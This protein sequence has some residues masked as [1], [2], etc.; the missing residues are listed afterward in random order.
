MVLYEAIL[1]K[2]SKCCVSLYQSA[3]FTKNLIELLDTYKSKKLYIASGSDQKEFVE[4]FESR[5]LMKYFP[6]I[7]GSP[8]LKTDIVFNIICGNDLK[9][10]LIGDAEADKLVAE[11]SNIDF[12][13]MKD[14]SPNNDMIQDNN[15]VSKKNLGELV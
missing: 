13:F 7:H 8:K 14:Y 15:L 4:V 3:E 2:Y 12:I 11:S 10:V 9:A 1:E 5:G 6:E